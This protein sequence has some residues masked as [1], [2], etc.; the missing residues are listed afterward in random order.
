MAPRKAKATCEFGDFQTP[1]ELAS[2]AV[3]VLKEIGFDPASVIEATCGRGAFVIAASDVFPGARVLAGEVNG[4]YVA[5]L[6]DRLAEGDRAQRDVTVRH[7]NFFETDWSAEA[8][9]LPDPLLI[10]GNYPWVTSA[11]LGAIQSSN[12]PAKSNFRGYGGLDALMGKSNFDISE[13]MLLRNLEWLDGRSGAIAMLCKTAVARKILNHAWRSELSVRRARIY[14]IDAMASFGAAVDAC[15]FFLEVGPGGKARDCDVFESLGA[16]EPIN[17]IGY[18]DHLIV[19]DVEAYLA[20]RDLCGQD[21]HYIWRSGIKHDCSR[22]ME[23]TYTNSTYVNGDEAVVEIEDI[24]L[25]PMLKSSDLGGRSRKERRKFMV[26]PQRAVGEPTARIASIAPHTW[27]YLRDNAEAL[28]ARG[29]TIYK[30]K[31]EFSIFGVGDYSFSP[32]KVAISG[33]YKSLEFKVI[34]PVGGKPV[35]FDDTVYFLAC[36]SE[37]EARLLHHLL[38]SEEV[39]SLLGSMVFWSDKRPITVDLLKRLNLQKV[40]E[41]L[42][43]EHEYMR[44]TSKERKVDSQMSLAL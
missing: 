27:R 21:P 3:A 35:V 26:V 38:M 30:G 43:V 40:A 24:F 31:P 6:K 39:Q 16:K 7:C 19:S 13:W 2:N 44:H 25:Y 32:W 29:S 28:G 9:K 12:L 23:L 22:V 11:A 37:D 10:T 18:H 1:D 4:Q 8:A 15:F 33:F 41:C 17:T 34:G 42:G 36:W 20:H 14:A 5:H